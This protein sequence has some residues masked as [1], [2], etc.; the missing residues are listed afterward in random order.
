MTRSLKEA[1]EIQALS[2]LW[3]GSGGWYAPD[4]GDEPSLEALANR[5]DLEL[6]QRGDRT[7]L[8]DKRS[9][10]EV[11]KKLFDMCEA[12]FAERRLVNSETREE[13]KTWEKK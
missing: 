5:D 11:N 9:L 12:Q 8:V 13:I 7:M 4:K 2:R 3:E 1:E 10:E 6:V